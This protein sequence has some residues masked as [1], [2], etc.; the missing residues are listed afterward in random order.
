M[1]LELPNLATV[2]GSLAPSGVDVVDLYHFDVAQPSDVRLRLAQSSGREFSVGLLTDTGRRIGVDERQLRV[3]LAPGH[4]VA[5]IQ[6]AV[7]TEAGRYSLSLVVRQLTQTTLTASARETPPGG[8]VTFTVGTV[9]APDAGVLE[10]EIDRF[11]PLGGW[12]FERLLRVAVPRGSISW[13][14]PALGRWRAH[15]RFRGTLRFSPSESGYV[16]VVVAKPLR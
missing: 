13:R 4:Y 10:L 11:D 7:G 12:Q 14:P 5:A 1:G 6:G 3:H 15:A 2:H 9:P 8:S 16:T